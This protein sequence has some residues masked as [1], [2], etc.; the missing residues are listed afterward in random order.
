MFSCHLNST[1]LLGSETR[2]LEDVDIMPGQI[3]GL[4]KMA[5]L[6]DINRRIIRE[7]TQPFFYVRGPEERWEHV[8]NPISPHNLSERAEKDRGLV[9]LGMRSDKGRIQG[10]GYDSLLKVSKK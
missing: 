8:L 4:G 1:L 9:R 6:L 2:G 7:V 3:L 5:K 10:G